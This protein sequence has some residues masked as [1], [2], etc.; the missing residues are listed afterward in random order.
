MIYLPFVYVNRYL[1][2]STRSCNSKYAWRASERRSKRLVWNRLERGF[3]SPSIL[4]RAI[5]CTRPFKF[6]LPGRFNCA[7]PSACTLI[8]SDLNIGLRCC[9]T[10]IS[11]TVFAARVLESRWD[12]LRI[13][14]ITMP[15]LS[16]T[17][18]YI[19]I[20]VVSRRR[21]RRRRRDSAAR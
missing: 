5:R 18:F 16:P 9:V 11:V 15:V 17:Y 1:I 13:T 20:I 10:V 12:A 7:G 3:S 21:R 4:W 2:P 14:D 19:L 8:G 6:H